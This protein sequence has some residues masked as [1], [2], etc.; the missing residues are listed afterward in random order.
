MLKYSK[1]A[2]WCG[3]GQE[4]NNQFR[5]TIIKQNSHDQIFPIELGI[6]TNLGMMSDFTNLSLFLLFLPLLLEKVGVRCGLGG[7]IIIK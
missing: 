7:L 5:T 1:A 2:L 3:H 4:K 6:W